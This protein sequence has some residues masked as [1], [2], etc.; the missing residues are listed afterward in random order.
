MRD[1]LILTII[2]VGAGIAV[3]RPWIGV[4]LWAWVSLMNPHRYTW[5]FAY[6][7]PVAALVAGATLLG[8]LFTRER[9]HPFKGSPPV[10][11]AIFMVWITIS[12]LMGLDPAD[13][14]AAWDKVMKIMFMILVTLALLRTKQ[15]IMWL[16]W[17]CAGSL[18][19]L[20][21]KGGLFTILT[22]GNYLV[23]G[24]PGSFIGD[25]NALATALVMTIPLLRFLQLQVA[26]TWARHGMTV[27]MVLV[28]AAALGS[29]SRGALLAILAMTMLLWWRGRARLVGGLAIGIVATALVLFMPSE[30]GERM[31]SIGE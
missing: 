18:A 30:W 2:I 19:L 16:A 3:W 22:G 15:H 21:A 7:A 13:D 28:A 25:N 26:R 24:P 1:V 29:H 10:V 11:L 12:W 23:W 9:D 20:G 4:M 27:V 6:D 17:V 14:Y 8:F 31:E 5:G